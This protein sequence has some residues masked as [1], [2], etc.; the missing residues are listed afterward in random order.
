MDIVNTLTLRHIKTHKKRSI[1]TV[2][3]IIVSVAMV[4]AVFTSAISFVKYFQN[5]TLAI[6]GD[7]HA[8]FVDTDYLNHKSIYEKDENIVKYAV[9][10]YVGVTQISENQAS[11]D[12]FDIFSANQDFWEMRNIVVSKGRYPQNSNEMLVCEKALNNNNY[13][14]SLGE[15]IKLNVI[16]EGGEVAEKEYLIVGYTN[17]KVSA[18]DNSPLIT[19]I[20][21]SSF[22]NVD[23][24]LVYVK[25]DK[26]D[27]NVWDKISNTEK[28]VGA[29]EY[30]CNRE[31]FTYSGIMK[32][33]TM[34]KSLGGFAGILLLIIAV[35]SIFMIYDSFAVSYQERA[36]YLGMLASVGATKKQKRKSIYFEGFIFGLIGIPVGIASGIGGIAVTFK[37]IEKAFVETMAFEY[38]GALRVYINWMVIVGTILASAITIFIS[39]YIPAR[40]ASKATAIEAIRRNNTVKVK[41]AKKLRASKLTEKIFGY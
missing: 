40:K 15:K 11:S 18:T 28:A 21:N 10:T 36:R 41:K 26:L 20:D 13:N 17:S 39:S 7:W 31:L 23:S 29:A 9:R 12:Q 1:L 14:F 19:R 2:L 16:T 8:K 34:L 38:D 6:D 35:V 30:S 32:D 22:E 3:A 25:Y 24:A 27:N 4:S 33:N 37:F 5:V